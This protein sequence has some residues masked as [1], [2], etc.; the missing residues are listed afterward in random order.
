[1]QICHNTRKTKTWVKA[2]VTIGR[3]LSYI[4]T[5]NQSKLRGKSDMRIFERNIKIHNLRKKNTKQTHLFW[6]GF[7]V[8]F[9][10]VVPVTIM[11]YK[12]HTDS[13]NMVIVINAW[14]IY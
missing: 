2:K 11:C 7:T 1:M 3:C 4:R 8:L 10:N 6:S 5:G 9:N 12:L 13:H 14:V